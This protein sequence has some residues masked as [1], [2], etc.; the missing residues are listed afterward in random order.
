MDPIKIK[1][2]SPKI[3]SKTALKLAIILWMVFS[4]GYICWDVW[5]DFKVKSV[6][7]A[8]QTGRNETVNQLISQAENKECQPFSVF[9]D[10]KQI[11]L[12][13]IVCLGKAK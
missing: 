1:K 13:N 8:Y 12:I 5:N 6:S 9:T 3:S 2:I 4:I 11:Q 7:Q 10:Q